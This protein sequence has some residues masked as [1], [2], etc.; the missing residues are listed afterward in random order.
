MNMFGERKTHIRNLIYKEINK[1]ISDNVV[2][3]SLTGRDKKKIIKKNN[4][5][6]TSIC[7]AVKK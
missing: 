2:T 4:T 6:I 5:N 3:D 1:Y 7:R